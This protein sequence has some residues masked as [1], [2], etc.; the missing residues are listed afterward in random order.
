MVQVFHGE[1]DAI[2]FFLDSIL[3]ICWQPILRPSAGDAMDLLPLGAKNREIQSK[4]KQ[5]FSLWKFQL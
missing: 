1:V 2:V 5:H 4:V 3:H